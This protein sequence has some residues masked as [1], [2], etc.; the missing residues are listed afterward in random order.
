MPHPKKL[1]RMQG[2]FSKDERTEIE[3]LRQSM[4]MMMMMRMMM[5]IMQEDS[6]LSD[7]VRVLD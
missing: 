4:L 7:E 5:M 2:V 6:T 1:M 3:V